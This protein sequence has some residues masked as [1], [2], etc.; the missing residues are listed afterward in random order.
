M[1]TVRNDHDL[2]YDTSVGALGSKFDRGPL[3]NTADYFLGSLIAETVRRDLLKLSPD[4]KTVI[5][6]RVTKL[7]LVG[8]TSSRNENRRGTFRLRDDANHRRRLRHVFRRKR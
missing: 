2:Y 5:A 4:A 7:R 3:G 6:T 8:P 1:R